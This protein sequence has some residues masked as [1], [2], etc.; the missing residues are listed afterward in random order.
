MKRPAVLLVASTFWHGAEANGPVTSI[1]NMVDAAADQFDFWILSIDRPN[2]G[3]AKPSGV[4]TNRWIAANHHQ[5]YY[6]PRESVGVYS[7][8]KVMGATEHD[9]LHLN[10]FFDRLLTIPALVAQFAGLGP[11]RPTVLSPR[12]EF[13]AGAL[14]FK[15]G[16]K[17]AYCAIAKA[18]HLHRHVTYQASTEREVEDI[19]AHAPPGKGL[20]VAPDVPRQFSSPQRTRFKEAGS[21]RI[22][23]LGRI[24]PMKN[25]EFALD[26][27]RQAAVSKITF[28]L[29]GPTDEPDY[30]R[31]VQSHMARMPPHVLVRYRG[32]LAPKLFS[33]VLANYDLFFLPSRG[34]NFSHAIA[35]ALS[36]GVPALISDRTPWLDLQ[37]R[38]SGAALS[39]DK[40]R[41]FISEI[42][43]IAHLDEPSWARLSM[44]ALD[45][46]RSKI[47]PQMAADLQT[48]LYSHVLKTSQNR[49]Y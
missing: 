40:P 7:V 32:V 34:E 4:P 17:R 12:G 49:A 6:L 2:L 11:R 10:S 37:D 33:Q 28:D 47:S 22:F 44:G 19:R 23:F 39:L 46:V 45:Y 16:R 20:M 43:R 48:Q 24:S 21:V 15:A 26:V 27:I 31:F 36:C 14:E 30:W 3:S 38:A 18:I 8:A 29:Y 35:E 5:V 25:L 13:A 9:L 42:E 1:Q 41:A